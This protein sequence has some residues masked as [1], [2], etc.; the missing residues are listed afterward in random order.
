MVRGVVS[1]LR[2]GSSAGGKGSSA[3]L[4]AAT[5]SVGARWLVIEI[6]G[7]D[8]GGRGRAAENGASRQ[9]KARHRSDAL[10]VTMTHYRRIGHVEVTRMYAEIE[11]HNFRGIRRLAVEQLGRVNLLVGPNNAGKTS[12]L[13]ALWLLQAPGNPTLVNNAG[14]FRGLSTQ[15][16]GQNPAWYG[17]FLNMDRSARIQIIGRLVDG[18]TEQLSISLANEWAQ[19]SLPTSNG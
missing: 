11:L 18:R 7:L 19:G 15:L 4:A 5:A 2:A 17:L 1:W 8:F 13:E 16:Q 14:G 3:T 10:A 6:E 12:F 9:V